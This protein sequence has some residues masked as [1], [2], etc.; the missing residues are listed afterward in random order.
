MKMFRKNVMN[1][2]YKNKI[3]Q[4][5]IENKILEKLKK[6]LPKKTLLKFKTPKWNYIFHLIKGLIKTC[7]ALFLNFLQVCPDTKLRTPE[8]LKKFEFYGILKNI[9]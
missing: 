8:S 4:N 7:L 6:K 1:L 3:V 5:T 9:S 2:K